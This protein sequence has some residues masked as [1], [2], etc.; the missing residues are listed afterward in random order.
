VRRRVAIL[1]AV[2]IPFLLFANVFMAYRHHVLEEQLGRLEGEHQ[3]LL[4]ENKRLITGITIL[5]RPD[6]IH[7]LATEELGLE[8]IDP[9]RIEWVTVPGGGGT[10]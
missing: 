7:R 1:L 9:S 8:L 4:E 10:P 6:R 3:R 2:A 5:E